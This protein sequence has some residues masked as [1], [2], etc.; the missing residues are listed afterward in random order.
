VIVDPPRRGLS[1]AARQALAELKPRALVY[2]SCEPRTLARDLFHF[3]HLGLGLEQVTAWDMIPLSAS[4]ESLAILKPSQPPALRILYQDAM[5]LAIELPPLDHINQKSDT[6]DRLLR[7]IRELPGNAEA[8]LLPGLEPA[9][10]GICLA[11]RQPAALRELGPALM[12]GKKYYLSLVRGIIRPKGRIERPAHGSRSATRYRRE[13]VIG[14]HSLIR[15]FSELGQR[16]EL[17]QHLASI[18]HPVL[19]DAR[20]GDA[21]SNRFFEE[22]HGLDR[23]FLH[24]ARVEFEFSDGAIVLESKLAPDLAAVLGSVQAPPSV[25]L[26]EAAPSRE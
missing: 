15:A 16:P 14:T 20:F 5:L 7:R 18:G 8:V 11:L 25:D 22:R 2:V 13:R 12:A 24:C 10:S 4:V 23:P 1:P 9:I 26:D 3:R 6:T 21:A 17:R 19:G